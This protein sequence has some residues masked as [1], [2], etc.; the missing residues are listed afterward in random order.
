[1]EN[2]I[3]P[4]ITRL[5]FLG[6]PFDVLPEENFDS[7]FDK[8]LEKKHSWKVASLRYR[9]FKRAVFSKDFQ[10]RLWTCALVF[11]I[12]KSLEWGMKFSGLTAPQRYHP[13][14]FVIRLLGYLEKKG[15]SVYILGGT[16]LEVQRVFDRIRSGFPK[17]TVVGRYAGKYPRESESSIITAIAK[18]S[19]TFILVGSRVRGKF[20]FLFENIKDLNIPIAYYSAEAFN[21]MSGKKR[22][23]D[24]ETFK[25]RFKSGT[26]HLPGSLLNPLKWLKIPG[27]IF[28]FF[29]VLWQKY[30]RQKGRKV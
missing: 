11:P 25:K 22:I 16:A 5:D 24:R 26:H 23:P 13:F 29:M 6:V 15:K 1:M 18:S 20:R 19:P 30:F 8:L 9:D 14:D 12:D 2:P 4:R 28:Y 10:N 7:F 27:Y 17:L 3:T 21:I